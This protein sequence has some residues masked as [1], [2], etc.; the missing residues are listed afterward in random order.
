MIER[1]NQKRVNFHPLIISNQATGCKTELVPQMESST[2]KLTH[3]ADW[4]GTEKSWSIGLTQIKNKERGDCIFNQAVDIAVKTC[5]V[6]NVP[7]WISITRVRLK[8][9]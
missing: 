1:D 9:V 3:L 2:K 6:D 5:I 4:F 8:L 7:N